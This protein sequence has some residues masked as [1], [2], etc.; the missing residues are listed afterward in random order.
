V[1]RPRPIAAALGG[2]NPCDGDSRGT[3]TGRTRR[4]RRAASRGARQPAGALRLPDRRQVR[5]RTGA[6]RARRRATPGPRDRRHPHAADAYD[7]RTRR[8]A[9]DPGTLPGDGDPRPLGARRGR[10]RDGRARKRRAQRVPLEEPRRRRRQFPRDTRAH[11]Q[12]RLR[13]RPGT[14]PG[15][16]RR[17]RVQN[18]LEELSRASAR[19]WR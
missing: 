15:A 12:G 19:C 4:R 6:A 8:G 7:R 1:C 14:R 18:P 10:A 16:R 17:A 5:K 11:H 13:R 3:Y 9:R 2:D